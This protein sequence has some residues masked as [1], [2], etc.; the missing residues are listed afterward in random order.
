MKIPN[1]KD[2]VRAFVAWL[3]QCCTN[4]QGERRPLYDKRRRYFLY[5]NN[6]TKIARV[7][8]LD[9]HLALLRSFLFAGDQVSWAVSAPAN[10]DDEEQAKFLAIQDYW[11]ES[12]NASGLT[13][14]YDEA[15]LWALCHDTMILKLGW[16]DRTKQEFAQIVEPA[17]FGVFEEYLD[18]DSQQAYTHTF[19]IDY[20]DAVNRLVRAGLPN[21]IP[22]L[23]PTGGGV[24]DLGLPSAVSQLI[25]AATGGGNAMGVSGNVQGTVNTDFEAA[26]SYTPKVPHSICAFHE[27][28][29]WDD[30]AQDWRFFHVIDPDI[31]VSDSKKTIAALKL[32]GSNGHAPEY[33]SQTNFFLKGEHPFVAITPFPL[34]NYTWG[35]SHLED[36]I[37]LQNWLLE[38]LTQID[39]ILDRQSD[40]AVSF[41]GYS[42]MDD[43]RMEA[44]GGP[45][46]FAQDP[47]PGARAEIHYP[48]MPEDLF[49][50]FDRILALFMER[51]GMT[52]IMAGR[53]ER[54]VRGRGHARELR[55]TG[56][57]RVRNTATKLESSLTQLASKGLKL[58]AKNDDTPLRTPDGKEFVLAQV[59][60]GDDYSMRVSGHSHSP[61]FT[62]EST[63]IA[64]ALLKTKAITREWLLRLIKPP[65]LVDLI[66]DLRKVAKAEQAQ[67]AEQQKQ[68]AL[69][70]AKPGAKPRA[71]G[72]AS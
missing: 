37:P 35:K 17:M 48:T 8:E 43:E 9:S 39:E 58:K 55:T 41:A 25:I 11:N 7:N 68:I 30:E 72:A 50:E 52:E 51:S 42:G 33:E 57:G 19:V 62:M 20:D 40:P 38:R 34:Y 26:P 22:N 31:I 47:L 44:W 2:Q 13:D 10:A 61:L 27:V 32:A 49:A 71:S 56:A 67:Q 45:G 53:G 23:K 60:A 65:H 16:N 1:D 46:T 28:T 66:Q 6:Q 14:A 70:L 12:A 59:L 29:V 3:V 4:S 69:G 15:L 63:D 5:G 21:E 64:F 24:S 18:F 36:L 54:N